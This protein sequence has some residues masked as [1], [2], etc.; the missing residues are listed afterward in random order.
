MKMRRAP[1]PPPSRPPSPPSRISYHSTPLLGAPTK[2]PT[3]SIPTYVLP[4]PDYMI[5]LPPSS[6]QMLYPRFEAINSEERYS[7]HKTTATNDRDRL[8]S[9]IYDRG[10]G[11]RGQDRTG[12]DR[13]DRQK[14]NS[15]PVWIYL[16]KKVTS[17]FSFLPPSM[18]CGADLCS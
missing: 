1:V 11:Q 8:G 16:T 4:C 14:V 15:T 17:S 9:M 5:L 13:T 6:S 12:Q 7:N 10:H 3:P 2:Q 18:D